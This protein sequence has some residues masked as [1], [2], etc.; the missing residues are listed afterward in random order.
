MTNKKGASAPFSL[1]EGGYTDDQLC[2]LQD[3]KPTDSIL[4]RV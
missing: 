3:N 2:F 1:N 4:Q